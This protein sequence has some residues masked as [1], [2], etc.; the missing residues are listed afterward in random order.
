MHLYYTADES[1]DP[2]ITFPYNKEAV[3]QTMSVF[4]DTVE[5]I[6]RKDFSTRCNNPKV[7]GECDFRH[8]CKSK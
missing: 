5:K 1:A 3:D 2:K 7:C 4:D 8:Y 6:M